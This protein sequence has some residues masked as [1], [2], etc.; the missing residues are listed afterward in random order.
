MDE[1]DWSDSEESDAFSDAAGDDSS[2]K[3]RRAAVKVI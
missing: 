3:V 2:W 1:D